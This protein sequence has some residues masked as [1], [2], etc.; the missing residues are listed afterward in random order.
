MTREQ[1]LA[2]FFGRDPRKGEDA[3]ERLANAGSAVLE[4]VLPIGGRAPEV[5]YQAATIR[6]PRLCRKLG[7]VAIP[8]L[9]RVI[10]EA[11]WH[12]KTLA[13][14]CFSAFPADHAAQEGLYR[15]LETTDFDI[16]R[17]A[18]EACG[19]N[20]Y[21]DTRIDIVDLAKFGRLG[22]PHS[23]LIP[24]DNY[25]MDKLHSYVIEALL[26]FFAHEGNALYLKLC[27]DFLDV[28]KKQFRDSRD[29]GVFIR[30]AFRELTPRAADALIARW[31]VHPDAA[32]RGHAVNG[33]AQLR[34]C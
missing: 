13:S 15:L 28:C 33:L 17:I 29:T 20:N 31:L 21:N 19:Y 16:Q 24:I 18:I 6:L 27:E 2:D 9:L 34:A 22:Q 32:Y 30:R 5:S 25:S 26:R 23:D 14:P 3:L 10:K 1:D 7:R 12:T 8:H 4:Q 11:S